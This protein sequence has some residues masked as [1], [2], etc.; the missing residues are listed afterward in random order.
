M[1]KALTPSAD[2]VGVKLRKPTLEEFP[3]ILLA[4]S[5]IA[6]V[7]PMGVYR[8]IEGDYAVAIVDFL[9]VLGFFTIGWVVY[10]K[11]SVRTGSVLMAVVAMSAAVASVNLRG[12]GQIIWM[13]PALVAMFYLLKPKEASCVSVLAIAAVSPTV[14]ASGDSGQIAIVLASLAVTTGRNERLW[15][16]TQGRSKMLP[17][18]TRATCGG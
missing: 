14:F 15:S 12:G 16:L 8:L 18:P 3:P 13:H 1:S 6:G 5:G 10:V 9:A 17:K 4:L 11:R 2:I 7:E